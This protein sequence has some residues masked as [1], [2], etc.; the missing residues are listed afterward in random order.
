MQPSSWRRATTPGE[1]SYTLDTTAFPNGEHALRL[2]VVR[3][4]SNYNEYV[5][6][7]TIAN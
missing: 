3:T 1:F 6:K 4:D 2:R 5:T 7:F